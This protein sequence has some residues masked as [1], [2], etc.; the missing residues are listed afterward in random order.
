[1]SRKTYEVEKMLKMV[2]DMCRYS[3]NESKAIRQGAMNVLE[4]V[5]HETGNYRGFRY[6]RKDEMEAGYTVGINCYDSGEVVSDFEL[7][8]LDTDNTRVEYY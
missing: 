4:A 5:L 7:R 8:F 1:M 3:V 2:N 6:L